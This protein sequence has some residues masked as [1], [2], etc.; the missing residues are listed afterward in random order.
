MTRTFL[1]INFGDHFPAKLPFSKN[2]PAHTF[3]TVLSTI[4][5]NNFYDFDLFQERRKLNPIY[6]TCNRCEIR[7][8]AVFFSKS[9]G[10]MENGEKHDN[11]LPDP[12]ADLHWSKFE[13]AMQN[14][15]ADNAEKFPDRIC[16]VET[17]SRTT[18]RRE[19]T[20][21]H[22]HETSNTLAH[23]F[24]QCGIENDEVIMIYAYRGVDLCV[25][26]LAI[27]KAGATFSVVDPAYGSLKSGAKRHS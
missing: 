11:V 22:I 9:V 3:V 8:E 13:G 6:T 18:P 4:A 27:L 23:Y 14:R 17:A 26:I 15:F 24:L 1:R 2:V 16:V 12:T 21:R 20:Y 7:H 19:F 5:A 10:R 25:A